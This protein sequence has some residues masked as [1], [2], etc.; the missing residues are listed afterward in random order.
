MLR[1]GADKISINTARNKTTWIYKGEASEEFGS[2]TI[3]YR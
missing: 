3:V 2:S 1:I